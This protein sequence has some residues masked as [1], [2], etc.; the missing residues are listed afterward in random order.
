MTGWLD[1]DAVLARPRPWR[2]HLEQCGIDVPPDATEADGHRAAV[3][4][5]RLILR[6]WADTGRME[7]ITISAG[8]R[9]GDGLIGVCATDTLPDLHSHGGSPVRVIP[10]RTWPPVAD[11][12]E[13]PGQRTLPL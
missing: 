9:S 10:R 6:H 11:V 2:W 12:D 1:F 8:A 3:R 13:M 5:R 7:C 4:L